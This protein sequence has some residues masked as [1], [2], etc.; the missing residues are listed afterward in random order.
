MGLFDKWMNGIGGTAQ[1][2]V[3]HGAWSATPSQP[4]TVDEQIKDVARQLGIAVTDA[5]VTALMAGRAVYMSTEEQGAWNKEIEKRHEASKQ[6][7]IEEFKKFPA[8]MRQY[9]IDSISWTNGMRRINDLTA[10]KSMEEL[11]Y[12]KIYSDHETLAEITHDLLR[13]RGSGLAPGAGIS[14]S[15]LAMMRSQHR[16]S[17]E[18]KLFSVDGGTHY[19]TINLNESLISLKQ[20]IDAHAE[21]CIADGLTGDLD[22]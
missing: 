16:K 13:G 20:L 15:M 12:E 19:A 21:Q 2:S 10:S 4:G 3:G 18:Q 1:G 22:K 9:I 17:T 14:P 8:S 5:E 11:K 7:K 6:L